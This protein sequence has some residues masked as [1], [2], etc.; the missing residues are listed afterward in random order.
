MASKHILVVDDEVGIRRVLARLLHRHGVQV[1]LAGDGIEAREAVESRGD[2]S[3]SA[4]FCDVRM[5]REDGVEFTAWL[6]Q[7]H[8]A[9]LS[10]LVLLTGDTVNDAVT[11]VAARTGCQLMA[12]PFRQ[13]DVDAMLVK[14]TSLSATP[15]VNSAH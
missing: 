10:R 11:A 6:E 9:L 12:K 15:A 4:I 5:P 8:P 14:L 7:R 1:E 3:W 13:H 2:G